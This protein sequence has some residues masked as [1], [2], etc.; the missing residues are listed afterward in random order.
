M[1][2]YLEIHGSFVSKTFFL[3]FVTS[4][5][6]RW[7]DAL[8][9]QVCVFCVCELKHLY[10][11]NPI[12]KHV[13]LT[14][15]I[16]SGTSSSGTSRYLDLQ[17]RLGSFDEPLVLFHADYIYYT[18]LSLNY[19]VHIIYIHIIQMILYNKIEWYNIPYLSIPNI[20]PYNTIPYS[21]ILLCSALVYPAILYYTFQNF[22]MIPIIW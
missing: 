14:C 13:P 19:I 8:R 12:N 22:Q 20:H 6:L 2:L 1:G 5:N 4:H 11:H 10:M 18:S 9:S 16:S 3:L 7:Q 21:T 15:S 17:A